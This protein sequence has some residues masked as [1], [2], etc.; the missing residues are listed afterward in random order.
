MSSLTL[1]HPSLGTIS[2]TER[3][4]SG[5]ISARWVNG[6]LR[7]NVPAGMSRNSILRAVGR[8]AADFERIRP[9]PRYEPGT[10]VTIATQDSPV[11][12]FILNSR[13]P[14]A[15]L[16]ATVT[17]DPATGTQAFAIHIPPHTDHT[18]PDIQRRIDAAVKA[19]G[20]RLAP[21]ILLPRARA[22][23]AS[24]GLR[25]D[26]WE[27]AHGRTVLG[28]C[29]PRLRRIRLSYLN[30][31]LT[32]ELRDYI[33]CHELAHLTEPGHTPAFHAL[34]D[35]Y[36]LGRERELIRRLHTYPWPIER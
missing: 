36:C 8:Y 34:C 33:I 10:V 18:L 25:V 1:S 11:R 19:V 32:P 14:V 13:A 30:V 35:R 2:V 16:T 3:R 21:A 24:L 12:I 26:S 6:Q 17:T 31:F 28:T 4:G 7:V 29:Y 27:I 9:R 5:K 23:A 15:D 22:I 20:R